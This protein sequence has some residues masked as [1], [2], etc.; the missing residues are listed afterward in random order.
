MLF[1]FNDVVNSLDAS[2]AGSGVIGS[3]E[4]GFCPCSPPKLFRVGVSGAN[5][6]YGCW[7]DACCV[8]NCV[9]G[10]GV[11]GVCSPADLIPSGGLS[12]VLTAANV[13]IS[14]AADTSGKTLCP[15]S[16]AVRFSMRCS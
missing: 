1:R 14:S 12:V 8:L 2:C 3:S 11:V 16:S 4:S 6:S 15:A 5:S 10:V 13:A 7:V 9:L